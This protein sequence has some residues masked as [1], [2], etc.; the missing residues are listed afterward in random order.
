MKIGSKL[1]L[2]SATRFWKLI[3]SPG[4]AMID[5]SWQLHGCVI[6]SVKILSGATSNSIS[7]LLERAT[8]DNTHA[9]KSGQFEVAASRRSRRVRVV[10]RTAYG[11]HLRFVLASSRQQ[12]AGFEAFDRYLMTNLIARNVRKLFLIQMAQTASSIGAPMPRRRCLCIV[13]ILG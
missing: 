1:L 6:E 11:Q 2:S 7:R 10:A 4:R 9:E 13:P 5:I 12:A 3:S 8:R